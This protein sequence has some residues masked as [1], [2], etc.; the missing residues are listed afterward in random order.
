MYTHQRSRSSLIV[1]AATVIMSL[2]AAQ[3]Y[4]AGANLDCVNNGV[5]GSPFSAG[6]GQVTVTGGQVSGAGA[7]LF[8]DFFRAPSS[9]ND[10][11]DVD[12]D[13]LAGNFSTFPFVDNLGSLWP[14]NGTINTHWM[15][16]YRSV[17]SVNGFNEF[18][19]NQTCNAIPLSVP[20]EAG[21]FNQ[22]EYATLGATTWA[23]PFANSS[24]TPVQPCEIEFAFL[25]VPS[26][27]AVQVQG[28]G[29]C[30]PGGV[31][32]CTTDSDCA[33]NEK[34]LGA[35]KWNAEPGAPGYGLNPIISSTG[36]V[37]QL[38]SLARECGSCANSADPCTEQKHCAPGNCVT[39]GRCSASQTLCG[40]TSDCPG[41][42][43]CV[44][45]VSTATVCRG[46]QNC[47]A[48]TCSVTPNSCRADSDCPI[49]E[50]CSNPAPRTCE[51]LEQC[52]LSGNVEEL[53]VD[54]VVP[55]ADTLFDFVGAWVPVAYIANRGTGLQNVKYSEMQFLFGTGRMP[56]G[57]NFAAATRSVG[58]GTRNAIMNS[59]GIDTSWGRG[60]NVGNESATTND[61]NLGSGARPSNAQ[62]SGQIETAVENFRLGVGYTG[63]AGPSRAAS[64]ALSGRYEVLNLC[65]DVDSDGNPLCDCTAQAC[66]EGPKFCSINTSIP[67][68]TS[69]DCN[70]TSTNGTCVAIDAAI[71]NAGYVRPTIGSVLDNCDACCGYTIGGNGSFVIRGNRNANRDPMD[72]NFLPGNPLDNQAVADYINNMDDSIKSFSGNVFGR[73]CDA[74]RSCSIT[75]ATDCNEDSDCPGGETCTG[76]LKTCTSDAVCTQ[77]TCSISSDGC[78]VNGDCPA[79]PQTCIGGPGGNCSINSD[80]CDVDGDC[81]P[82]AQ[83]CRADFCKS[84]LNM[85]G[86]FLA[87]T[88]FLGA[89]I[90]CQQ[91]L[92]DGMDFSP[93]VPLNQPLQNFIRA[94]NGLGI[95]GDTPAFGSVNPATGAR[96]P[97][98]KAISG[99][100][101]YSD[102]STTG[103]YTY[104]N[105][106]GSFIT[107][108]GSGQQLAAR[109]RL[110]GDF[111]EDGV[112]DIS[113]A[114]EM[115]KAYYFPRTWQRTDP[116]ATGAGNAGNQTSGG[117]NDNAIPEVIGDH[118][119]DGNFSKED[120]RYFMDG[121]AMVGGVLDR[122]QGA[123]AIDNALDDYGRCAGNNTVICRI[124]VDADCTD[125]GTTGPCNVAQPYPW[126]DPSNLL[127]TPQGLG[128]DPRFPVAKDVND[129]SEPML[130]TGKPY[131]AGDFRGDAA[132]RSAVPGAGPVGWDGFVD[133][134]DLDYC[135]R[136]AKIGSWSEINDAVYM[137]LSCD[138]NGDRD[139]NGSDVDELVQVILGTQSGDVNLDRVVDDADG[140]IISASIAGNP[141][142]DNATCGWADGDTNCDGFVNSTDLG[143]FLPPA[144]VSDGT[145]LRK[146][147]FVSMVA[148][149]AAFAVAGGNAE[150][151]L[152]IRID[153]MHNVVPPYSGGAT[154]PFTAF[155]GQIV[156]AG[157][158]E[159]FVESSSSGV[160]FVVSQASCAPHYRDWS[161]F[162]SCTNAVQLC[163]TDADCPGG[164]PGT[165]SNL[166]SNVVHITGPAIVP[167]SV[168]SVENIATACQGTEATC[169]L[170]SSPLVLETTRWGDVENPYNPPSATVQPDVTDIGALVNK[171][172]SAPGAPIKARSLIAGAPANVWGEITS[173][174]MTV[175]LGFSHIS[176]CVDAFRGTP[177]PYKAGKCAGN[178]SGCTTNSECGGA[179]PCELYCP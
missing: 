130:A 54:T 101:T 26:A 105:S 46:D 55:D 168:Y 150:T 142:N 74:T 36:Y 44:G 71:P 121:L 27:W 161:Q 47:S 8:V 60:D 28:N 83:T 167:S 62:G 82:V 126:A 9:T 129:V 17:G 178:N 14:P 48:G 176:A 68:T 170:A 94:N 118:N 11:I 72:P 67:C 52:S 134:Q 33:A 76:P 80:P 172:R 157:A 87:T 45:P 151:A 95:G 5:Q 90:D 32:S 42:E 140:A 91:S 7:T 37:S 109:N 2:G 106:G 13:G 113:D 124:G 25:D 66:G 24:G 122:K 49:G 75:T 117:A 114:A 16:Q 29:I 79:Q 73:E 19:E 6:S 173:A 119:G 40:V 93:T 158:P 89:G 31:T 34:C 21:I 30:V 98:R 77:K 20:A 88:F 57:E 123:I 146:T 149:A 18:V 70:P 96:V 103:S 159:V 39:N 100:A 162:V 144:L 166:I 175:D 15:F 84:K 22:F 110:Q 115:V 154:I 164:G 169:A 85:P 63:L 97:V 10:W 135:C 43:T 145:G 165:C 153:T 179:G 58:S 51:N 127:L 155:E 177:Y 50:T 131:A 3:L 108:F 125:H 136:M 156:Y 64:D 139:V 59:T 99:G 163:N 120:L 137:D 104:A 56:S 53:N 69:S 138:M 116:Q 65:K 35:A 128:L 78:N 86:Q 61:F 38:Q 174:V 107:N 41:G 112:R 133:E 143:G 152:R 102:G 148:P 23:G 147:R 92:T 4:A 81:N 160:R 141:C 132:G 111:N 12:G 1:V 171:F